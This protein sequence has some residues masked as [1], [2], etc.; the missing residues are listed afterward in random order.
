MRNMIC[1]EFPFTNYDWNDYQFLGEGS[2]GKVFK[3]KNTNT[4]DFV[5]VKKI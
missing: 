5:A 2:F 4:R 1:E 3:V